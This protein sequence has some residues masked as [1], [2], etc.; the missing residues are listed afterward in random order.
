MINFHDPTKALRN[1]LE[2]RFLLIGFVFTNARTHI[3]VRVAYLFEVSRDQR[4]ISIFS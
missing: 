2:F 4:R 3:P 1:L